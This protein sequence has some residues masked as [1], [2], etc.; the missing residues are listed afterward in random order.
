MWGSGTPASR[1]S[2]RSGT[3]VHV[4]VVDQPSTQAIGRRAVCCGMAIS[5]RAVENHRSGPAGQ[6]EPPPV[7]GRVPV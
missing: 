4:S 7:A 6:G 2:S 3:P 5:V 1:A